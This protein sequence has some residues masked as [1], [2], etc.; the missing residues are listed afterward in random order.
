VVGLGGRPPF[1]QDDAFPQPIDRYSKYR[2]EYVLIIFCSSSRP[3]IIFKVIL[4]VKALVW[5]R[6]RCRDPKIALLVSI[7]IVCSFDELL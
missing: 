6:M 4:I 1:P 5:F 7:S 2:Y 3:M